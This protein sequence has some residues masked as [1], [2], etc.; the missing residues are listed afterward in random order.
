M[1]KLSKKW[2]TIGKQNTWKIFTNVMRYHEDF[3]KICNA[4]LYIINFFEME[5]KQYGIKILIAI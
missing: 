1:L 4:P 2:K 5:D 3:F